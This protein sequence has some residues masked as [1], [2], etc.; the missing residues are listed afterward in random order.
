MGY[1]ET[2]SAL[3]AT[4]QDRQLSTK[5]LRKKLGLD[6]KRGLSRCPDC[7]IEP[8]LHLPAT[9]EAHDRLHALIL[10]LGHRRMTVYAMR[11]VWNKDERGLSLSQEAIRAIAD[12]RLDTRPGGTEGWLENFQL[13]TG[14][15][16]SWTGGYGTNAGPRRL[17]KVRWPEDLRWL[18][19]LNFSSGTW[20]LAHKSRWSDVITALTAIP[21]RHFQK[22]KGI[23]ASNLLKRLNS[24]REIEIPP[25]VL[26]ELR[27]KFGVNGRT[28]NQLRCAKT[29]LVLK[30]T[31]TPFEFHALDRQLYL[32]GLCRQLEARFFR[33]LYHPANKS[34]RLY[35]SS[36]L[37]GLPRE[38]RKW[39]A[40]RMG[41]WHVDLRAF[42][43]AVLASRLG[44]RQMQMFLASGDV[45]KRLVLAC[46]LSNQRFDHA[47]AAVKEALYALAFGSEGRAI[48]KAFLDAGFN[49]DAYDRFMAF[50]PIAD[51]RRARTDDQERIRGR[52]GVTDY[53]GHWWRVRSLVEMTASGLTAGLK[54]TQDRECRSAQAA[55]AQS[56]EMVVLGEALVKAM[57]RGDIEIRL[58]LHDGAY[59][60]PTEQAGH[61]VIG[62]AW[63]DRLEDDVRDALR[64]NGI[65]G[66]WLEVES[67][68]D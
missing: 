18:D 68:R 33:V 4:P 62:G 27:A 8:Q 20:D 58:F 32:L 47:K 6:N 30:G 56:A 48:K 42:Q 24:Q 26:S 35:T 49:C 34:V 3:S 36:P 55:C 19:E 17:Q 37:A 29:D 57:D 59:V 52:G 40:Q 38:Q 67:P 12:S 23:I 45:W 51:L 10:D 16:L 53:T 11:A 28:V 21:A 64:S 39:L 63:I 14:I 65:S 60:V 13:A 9:K 2:Q 41:W 44:C 46:G 15:T 50:G 66:T 61:W 25:A 31:G 5:E 1:V 22:P 43:L 7:I 54:S